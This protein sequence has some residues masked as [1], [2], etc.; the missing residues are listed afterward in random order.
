METIMKNVIIL[1]LASFF[2]IGIGSMIVFTSPAE[3]GWGDKFKKKM[4]E[5]EEKAKKE[6]AKIKTEAAKEAPAIKKGLKEAATITGD[7]AIVGAEAAVGAPIM[8]PNQ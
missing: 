6:A 7:V 4:K 5:E 2:L 8:I 3:A 1:V